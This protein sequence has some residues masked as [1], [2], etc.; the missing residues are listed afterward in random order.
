MKV[1]RWLSVLCIVVFLAFCGGIIW[2]K[3]QDGNSNPAADKPETKYQREI[4]QRAQAEAVFEAAV[5]NVVG[6]RR[7]LDKFLFSHY[8]NLKEWRGHAR[9]EIINRFG[10]VEATNIYFAFDDFAR[11]VSASQ[12]SESKAFSQ[13]P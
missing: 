8:D 3:Y 6:Y 13:K 12:I 10:G 7:T 1:P 5:T 9:V 11:R 4:R 2:F